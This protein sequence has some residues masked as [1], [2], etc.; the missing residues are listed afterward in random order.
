MSGGGHWAIYGNGL[1]A[2]V[3]AERLGS[4]GREVSLINPARSWGGIFGGMNI[5]GTVFDAGMTNFEFDLFGDA[6]AAIEAYVPGRKDAIGNHVHH[7]RR[8]LS[9]F[10]SFHPLPTPKMMHGDRMIDDLVLS[11]CFEVLG[12]LPDEQRE[13]IRRELEEIVANANPLHPRQKNVPGSLLETTPFEQVS[14]ANHGASFHSLFVEPM[15]GKVLGVPSVTV[16]AVFHRNG[17]A[18]LFYPETLLSQFGSA[19]QKLKP[20]IFHY[21]DDAHFGAFITRILDKVRAMSNVHIMDGCKALHV[22]AEGYLISTDG[23]DI[24]CDH[25]AW[26]GDLSLLGGESLSPG[27]RASLELFFL[28][29][30][31]SGLSGDF[32]VLLDPDAGSPFYRVTNQTRCC[33]REDDEQQIILECNSENWRDNASEQQLSAALKRYGIAPE[34]VL[35]QTHKTFSGALAIPSYEGMVEFETLRKAVK[36]RFPEVR[37][38]GASSGYVS[39]TLN[40]HVIQALQIAYAEGAYD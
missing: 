24:S 16:Q 32:A 1:S 17:W 34:A 38:M 8:Y 18:P 21:P 37:L 7:V 19:P 39:Q 6:V 13:A 36:Q 27:R 30:K 25:L 29:V 20:T 14:I 22:D 15:F 2:L 5:A 40:D 12:H 10:A 23:G 3:L 4:A 31:R 28:K 9:E 33:G 26:G 11:N 35:E